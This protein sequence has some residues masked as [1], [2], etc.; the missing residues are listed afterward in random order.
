MGS[1]FS[2]NLETLLHSPDSSEWPGFEAEYEDGISACNNS[3]LE[4]WA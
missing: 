1:Y 3:G 2:R 4:G